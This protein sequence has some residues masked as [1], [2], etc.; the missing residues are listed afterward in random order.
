MG[1]SLGSDDLGLPLRRHSGDRRRRI[2]LSALAVF[3]AFIGAGARADAAIYAV[4]AVGIAAILGLRFRKDQLIPIIG[5]TVTLAISLAL[6]IG[7]WQGS[8]LLTGLTVGNRPLTLA[9]HAENLLSIPSFWTGALGGWP[10]GW[11]DTPMYAMVS[12]LSTAVFFGAIFVGSRNVN[13]R[14]AIATT[15]TL[16]A[17][18]IVPFALVFQSRVMVGN[19]VQPRYFLPL[20]VIAV[21]VASLRVDAEQ[22]WKGMRFA[23]GGVALVASMSV[24]L[25]TNIERYT[26]GL[27]VRS[28][29]PGA[30]AEWWWSS[31]PAPS[32]T[33]IAGTIAFALM[34]VGLWLVLPS[35]NVTSDENETRLRDAATPL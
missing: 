22:S 19:V 17:L 18:V 23:L 1:D 6:Y 10:L 7:S 12:T 20:M 28:L 21:G 32:V 4:F 33:W 24:A 14:R 15:L 8:A 29:D 31:A 16:I 11:L 26:T 30:M 25:H 13:V 9:E 3:G 5:A 35:A 27:D 34:F 2:V